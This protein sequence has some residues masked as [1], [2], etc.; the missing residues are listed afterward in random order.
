MPVDVV[1]GI[2]AVATVSPRSPLIRLCQVDRSK[3]ASSMG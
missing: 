1:T 3:T 2:A